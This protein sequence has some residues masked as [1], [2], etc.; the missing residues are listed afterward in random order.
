MEW[1]HAVF[2]SGQE[3][4]NFLFPLIPSHFQSFPII[5][6]VDGGDGAGAALGAAP[7]SWPSPRGELCIIRCFTWGIH[8]HPNLLPSREKG[9]ENPSLGHRIDPRSFQ[10]GPMFTHGHVHNRTAGALWHSGATTWFGHLRKETA[11]KDQEALSA[12]HRVS[13]STATLDPGLL[14]VGTSSEERYDSRFG[15]REVPGGSPAWPRDWQLGWHP[16]ELANSFTP[17]IDP[18]PAIVRGCETST[19]S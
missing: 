11:S 17:R 15:L 7:S 12:I 10:G 1:A 5:P 4:A 9:S 14:R 6:P 18:F 8:P 13:P 19:A 16:L 2:R 3:W